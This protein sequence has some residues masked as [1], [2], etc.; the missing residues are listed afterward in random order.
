MASKSSLNTCNVKY[1]GFENAASL[2]DMLLKELRW[3]SSESTSTGRTTGSYIVGQLAC[4]TLRL[5][6]LWRICSSA[7]A[8]FSEYSDQAFSKFRT[9]RPIFPNWW[10]FGNH[11]FVARGPCGNSWNLLQLSIIA[12]RDTNI[13]CRRDCMQ[14]F[15]TWHVSSTLA[16]IASHA[17]G[18][19]VNPISQGPTGC[20]IKN[21]LYLQL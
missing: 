13:V 11:D 19:H 6:S 16:M 3:F 8:R 21:I 20:K 2:V 9:D 1:I 14:Q 12:L 15:N 4:M 17:Q 7:S 10:S 18:H 5:M